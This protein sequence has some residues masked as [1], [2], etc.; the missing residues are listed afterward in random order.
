MIA[1]ILCPGPSLAITAAP[2][3]DLPSPGL[4]IAV[5]RA[6]NF[7][8]FDWLAMGDRHGLTW[9]LPD[10][11]W[12]IT[13]PR[14]GIITFADAARSIQ[15]RDNPEE[16]RFW[17]LKLCQWEDLPEPDGPKQWSLQAALLFAFQ[18]GCRVLHIYGCDHRGDQDYDG[19]TSGNRGDDRWQRE[20]A[21]LATTSAYLTQ[22]GCAVVRHT[23]ER[24]TIA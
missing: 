15:A 12:A 4:V 19:N 7:M 5:N 16:A 8:P 10:G 18:S 14:L 24:R 3:R 20:A 21:D 6:A 11:A 17:G 22:R 23:P 9:R 13:P 2:L 1:R